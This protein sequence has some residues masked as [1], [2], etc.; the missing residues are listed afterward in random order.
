MRQ[1]IMRP[2]TIVCLIV[3]L[4]AWFG[5]LAVVGILWSGGTL[6]STTAPTAIMIATLAI[7]L[8]FVFTQ[9]TPAGRGLVKVRY[10]GPDAWFAIIIFTMM[11]G[12]LWHV[13]AGVAAPFM[14]GI[15]PGYTTPL[16]TG[17]LFMIGRLIQQRNYRDLVTPSAPPVA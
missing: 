14:R 2:L 12:V 13:L 9:M 5:T 15:M 3:A 10:F 7:Q 17:F 6:P 11:P 1:N 4:A 8:A 16:I